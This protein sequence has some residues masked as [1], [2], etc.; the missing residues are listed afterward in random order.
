M[1][2]AIECAEVADRQQEHRQEFRPLSSC[3]NC[4]RLGCVISCFRFF[5]CCLIEFR[6]LSSCWNCCRLG[7]V[8]SCFRFFSCC[9]IEF[10]P[11]SSSWNCCRL[12][13]V[14]SCFRF[15]SCC[16]IEFR[17]GSLQLLIYGMLGVNFQ[18][19]AV[20]SE[21]GEQTIHLIF[22]LACLMMMALYH[23]WG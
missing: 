12:G 17:P 16:L 22:M 6:P 4:C 20:E 15:F 18:W 9:L 3:W 5:S 13:C 7:C 14:I 19:D 11:L 23:V 8:I 21:F 1:K 2:S 10:R